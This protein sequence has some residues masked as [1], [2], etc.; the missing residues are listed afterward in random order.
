MFIFSANVLNQSGLA[1]QVVDASPVVAEQYEKALQI[2]GEIEIPISEYMTNIAPTE[3][4][5]ALIDDLR[6]EGENMTRREATQFI[7]QATQEYQQLV[8]EQV[9]KQMTNDEFRKSAGEVETAMFQQIKSAGRY[10]DEA[11]RIQAQ[12]VRNFFATQA[13]QMR[14]LPMD[15]Y[16]ASPYSVVTEGQRVFNQS[17]GN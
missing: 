1:Q 4:S 17:F 2:G 8:Q 3:A 12:F 6:V 11:A 7:D 9:E 5:V 16:R 14:M 13:T 10:T 15:L